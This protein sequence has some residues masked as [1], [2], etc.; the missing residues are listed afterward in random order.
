MRSLSFGAILWDLIDGKELIGGAPFNVAAHLARLGAES[1]MLTRIGQD[2]LGEN[3]LV[4]MERLGVSQR[5]VQTDPVHPTGWAAVDLDGQGKATFSFPDDPAYEFITA[6][7][8]LLSKLRDNPPDT[9]CFGTLEQKGQVTRQALLRILE[10]VSFREVLY[11]IN[12]RLDFYPVDI[13]TT[14]L[15]YTSILKLNDD[16][17]QM[18]SRRLFGEDL[19]ENE[20]CGRLLKEFPV[21]VICITKGAEGCYIYSGGSRHYIPG[22]QVKVA[23]T[24][25]SGD[26]FSAAFLKHYLE[27][28]DPQKA[29]EKGNALGAWVASRSG[30]VPD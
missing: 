1:H 14:S 6:E 7:E 19:G 18:V 3:A 23:D 15:A 22:I 8:M 4:H 10:T 13:L 29:G 27:T 30:A 12:I 11:D 16:E 20:L 28:G 17:A 24:V 2:R 5:F 9:L 25:G 26:A 21:R